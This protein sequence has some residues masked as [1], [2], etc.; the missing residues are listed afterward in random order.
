MFEPFWEA[1]C[2]HFVDF[3]IQ[4]GVLGGQFSTFFFILFL[5]LFWTIF[6][7]KNIKKKKNEK[8]GF[9]WKK[10]YYREGRHVQ[11]KARM[12]GNLLKKSNQMKNFDENL[13]YFCRTF[14]SR[15]QKFGRFQ[16]ERSKSEIIYGKNQY[17]TTNFQFITPQPCDF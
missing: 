6:C 9:D 10:P 5:T 7:K 4:K 1:L 11:K 15:F 14:S 2:P 12:T 16:A 17:Q 8:V 13:E 3:G